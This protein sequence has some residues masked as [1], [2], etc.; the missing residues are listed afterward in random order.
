MSIPIVAIGASAGGLEAISEL[1]AAL[2]AES[3]MA[4]ALVQHLDPAHE[5]LLPELL[6]KKTSMPVV[7]VRDELTVEAG[8]VYVIPPN[9]TLTIV[10][11]C[12]RLTRRPSGTGLHLPVDSLFASLAQERGSAAICVV[13]SGGNADGSRGVRAIKQ[14]GGVVFAQLPESAKFPSMPRKAIETG[15][16]DFVL[17]PD[18]IAHALVRLGHHPEIQTTPEPPPDATPDEPLAPDEE[19]N[20]RRLFRRLRSVHGVDFSHY[21]RSTLRRRLARRM[22][23]LNIVS[24]ADYATALESDSIETASLYQ[25][26]LIRVTAFFRDPQ[27]FEGL[28]AQVFPLLSATHS[29]K[30]P[31]RV[32]VPGCA[33]GE[34]VYSIAIALVEHLG[35]RLASIGV[36]IFG[37]DV[38]ETAIEL[39][40]AGAFSAH[41]RAG[42]IERAPGA[43]LRQARVRLHH[44]EKHPRPVH[45]RAPGRHARPALLAPRS[46]Q[47]PKC[48]HLPG[49]D[50]AASRD[51]YFPLRITS[52]CIAR[53]RPLGDRGNRE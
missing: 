42:S 15:C 17:R 40:R 1:L 41:H 12:F 6:A 23:L 53:T 33:S 38:S 4:F 10:G 50:H 37:T 7:Q 44:R 36:Q 28:S 30:D 35:E 21:K 20:L 3:N 32:W 26:F 18:Q 14:A 24:L 29:T 31:I 46:H 39:A 51:A 34:E 8:H 48:P 49:H 52:A 45:L 11:Q 5:S 2:P 13:L 9:A 16:V 43:L 19:V 22:A 27:S 47:L 25:D